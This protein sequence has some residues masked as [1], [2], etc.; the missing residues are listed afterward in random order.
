MDS[1][2]IPSSEMSLDYTVRESSK[3][4]HVSL[5]MSIKGDLEVIV[6]KG[7]DQKRIPEILQRKQRWIERV[8]RRMATQQALVGTD[9]LVEQPQQIV[10]QA[11]A[12]TWQ[13]EYHPTRRTGIVIQERPNSVLILQGNTADSDYCKA[14]L[15]QWVAH[16]ARL[17]LPPWLQTVSKKLKLPF[18]QVSIRQQKTIWGSCSIR[19]T[20]SLNCKL[21][22]LPSELVHYV[23]VHELC[24]TIHLNHSK[25]FWELVGRHEPNYKTLDDSLRDARYFVPWWM[26]Q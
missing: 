3:A 19:K 14:A 26:E 20:V 11:I 13:V 12:Q 24:H 10:L 17:H 7:F 4:K 2:V 9:V 23:L 22:F 25:D 6:P 1:A 15:Q 5:K 18:N 8:S 21:L 16:K